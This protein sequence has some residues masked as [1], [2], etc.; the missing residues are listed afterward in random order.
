MHFKRIQ[1]Q[2][3]EMNKKSG[4]LEAFVGEEEKVEVDEE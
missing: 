1:T 3:D 2:L 4:I